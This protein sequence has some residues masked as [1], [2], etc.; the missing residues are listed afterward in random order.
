MRKLIPL[1]LLVVIGLTAC[2]SHTASKKPKKTAVPIPTPTAQST[3]TSTTSTGSIVFGSKISGGTVQKPS[4]SFSGQQPIAWVAT[5]AKPAP[6][7][8][9]KLTVMRLAGKGPHPATVTSSNVKVPSSA[10]TEDGFFAA[11]QLKSLGI[12]GPGTYSLTYT[13]AGKVY[14][15]GSFNMTSSQGTGIGY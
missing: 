12:T 13:F 10:K 8:P 11:K 2:G 7:S 9:L 3:K 5:L 6:V 1:L 14:A 15:K 4:K